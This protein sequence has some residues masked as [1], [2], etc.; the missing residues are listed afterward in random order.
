MG[1][2]KKLLKSTPSVENFGE[3]SRFVI[4][5]DISWYSLAEKPSRRLKNCEWLIY[6][7]TNKNFVVWGEKKFSF[8]FEKNIFIRGDPL[9]FF[10]KMVITRKGLPNFF[11]SKRLFCSK[12][13]GESENVVKSCAVIT[14]CP[15]KMRK[16]VI[17]EVFLPLADI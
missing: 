11:W 8:F 10:E 12:L 13:H 16:T 9:V 15:R 17:S 4:E 2:L 1:N 5:A 14:K 6:D 3:K 7:E